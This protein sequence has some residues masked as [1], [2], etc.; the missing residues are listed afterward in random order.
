MIFVDTEG[1]EQYESVTDMSSKRDPKLYY[2]FSSLFSFL[3]LPN[4]EKVF[5]LGLGGASIPHVYEHFYPNTYV[6][7][8]E[9]DSNVVQVS[10]TFSVLWKLIR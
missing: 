2:V 10:K 3:Y 1:N 7:V 6:D 9:I 5:V 8:V 4:Q